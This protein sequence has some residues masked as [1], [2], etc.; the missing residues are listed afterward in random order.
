MSPSKHDASS[1]TGF[2]S[3][4]LHYS[5]HGAAILVHDMLCPNYITN[6]RHD[7]CID[8][9]V[10]FFS[11]DNKITA[12]WLILSMLSKSVTTKF[13]ERLA[14]HQ[15]SSQ[16]PVVQSTC[17]VILITGRN[18]GYSNNFILFYG[19][20]DFKYITS[21]KQPVVGTEMIYLAILRD[22]ASLLSMTK[23]PFLV[24][25]VIQ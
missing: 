12:E 5:R 18:L 22:Q 3:C 9:V 14:Q 19:I 13:T 24:C 7:Q 10:R 1:W 11:L 6:H 17:T 2:Q 8:E 4:H 23:Y 16:S 20:Y 25:T 15:T 21:P